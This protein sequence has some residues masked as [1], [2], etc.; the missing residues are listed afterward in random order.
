MEMEIHSLCLL[1]GVDQRSDHDVVSLAS[2]SA[3]MVCSISAISKTMSGWSTSASDPTCDFA[4][5]RRASSARPTDTSQRGDSSMI[6]RDGIINAGSSAISPEGIRQAAE[7]S[8]LRV[9][10]VAQAATTAPTYQP[11]LSTGRRV[12]S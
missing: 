5:L 8:R 6:Q 2:R 10:K 12:S 7:V 4:R 9:P 3:A 11:Q 1:P